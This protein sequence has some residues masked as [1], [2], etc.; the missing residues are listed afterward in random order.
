MVVLDCF[1][2][3][4]RSL[5]L[6]EISERC[7]MP[8]TTV[9]RL[10]SSLREVKL[11]EQDKGRDRYRMGIRLFE[12]GSI[13]LGNL[14]VFNEARPLV[15]RLIKA[16]GEGSHLC[17]FDGTNMV[18]VE[19]LEP[20]GSS[21]NWTTT[22]SISPSYCT[23]VGKA[24]L[25]FQDERTIE[26]IIKQGLVPY[27]PST[28]TDPADLR[29]ELRQI[30]KRGYAVDE[31]EHQPNI[32]CVAAPIYNAADRVFA[33]ISVSGPADRL[34]RDRVLTIAPIVTSTADQISRSLGHDPR[35]S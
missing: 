25:A 17:V 28:I 9:H 24:A 12:L 5:S 20:S 3:Y 31:G 11:L 2:R 19:H 13:V 32:R 10:V 21:V 4:D 33:A 34:T 8:K 1:N 29:K 22:L 27:T 14:D 30:A 15:D 18:S 16:T 35:R 23:G 6:S 7:G 26:K